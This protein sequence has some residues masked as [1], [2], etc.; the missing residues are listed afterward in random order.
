MTG[1]LSWCCGVVGSTLAF[2]SIGHG[3]E[4]EHC[5]FSHHSAS[6]FSKLRSLASAHW[7]IQFVDC[8][9]SLSSLPSGEGESSSSGS[10]AGLTQRSRKGFAYTSRGFWPCNFFLGVMTGSLSW[11]CGVVGSTLAFRSIGHGFESEHSLFSHHSASAFSKLRSLASAHWMIQ[12]VDC[13]SSLS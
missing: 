5:L 4:S 10:A 11:H 8:C 2:G 13:C 9:S 7:M 12:F 3:F 1:G 6:A